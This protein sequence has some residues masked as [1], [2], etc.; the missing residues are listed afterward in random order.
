MLT[1]YTV[2]GVVFESRTGG[3]DPWE[4]G[5]CPFCGKPKHFYVNHKNLVFDCKRCGEHGSFGD[6]LDRIAAR[7]EVEAQGGPLVSLSQERGIAVET[8]TRWRVGWNGRQYTIPVP[9]PGE[10][11]LADLR[12]FSF[13]RKTSATPGG[14][15]WIG[16]WNELQKDDSRTVYLC[17]GEWDGMVMDEIIHAL[18]LPALSVWITG[19][20]IFKR[21]WTG[22]FRNRSVVSLYDNDEAGSRGT[23]RARELIGNLVSRFDSLI[24]PS[25]FPTGFDLR[26]LY[27]RFERNARKT[28][29]AICQM[30][31]R[32]LARRLPQRVG[33]QVGLSRAEVINQYQEWMFLPDPDGLDVVFATLFG[34]RLPGDPLWVFLVAPAGGSKSE[35]LMSLDKAPRIKTLTS[36]TPHALIS[37]AVGPGGA[38]PSLIPKLNNKVLVIKDFTAILSLHPTSRDEILGVLRDAYDGRIEKDF[39]VGTGLVR[40]YK[41]KFGILA[42]VTPAVEMFTS[43]HSS[44]GERFVRYRMHKGCRNLTEEALITR[45]LANVTH[46]DA[47]REAL[48]ATA[49]GVLARTVDGA[50]VLPDRFIKR[51]VALAWFAARLRTAVVRDR[52][53]SRLEFYPVSE[54]GTR[55][56][57]QFAKFLL[58]LALFHQS[59]EVTDEHYRLV[60]RV[61]M[62][63]IP[64]RADIV[65]R[66]VWS[67]S[68]GGAVFAPTEEI[69]TL[70][71]MNSETVRAVLDDLLTLQLVDVQREGHGRTWRLS[72]RIERI[73]RDLCL[74]PIPR[75]VWHT[76]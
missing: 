54:M 22:A 59:P 35:L 33:V 52:Y 60:A 29:D 5:A 4:V 19:A 17:E 37:G 24:W 36:L 10:K 44:L 45:A 39:G 69:I 28:Y 21:E 16:G 75:K 6:F 64:D 71:R 51:I 55:L 12:I 53:S 31:Q 73:V 38:D 3:D 27:K 41:S 74:Y 13:G 49:A 57:K 63:T 48:Q 30:L 26:E 7:N 1:G 14:I 18:Q 20:G 8:L 2:H 56:A 68:R 42:G 34:N 46:E 72:G 9:G 43:M 40:S 23:S 70:A 66:S 65:V 76:A 15:I 32:P 47:M 58:G 67:V 25:A 11:G 62:D 50:P 61:A